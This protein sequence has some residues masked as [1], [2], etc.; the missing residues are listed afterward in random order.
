VDIDLPPADPSL[1]EIAVDLADPTFDGLVLFTAQQLDGTWLLVVD[2]AGRVVWA[3]HGAE[4]V[5]SPTSEFSRDGRSIRFT[6]YVP[7]DHSGGIERLAIDGREDTVFTPVPRGHHD[8]VELPDGTLAWWEDEVRDTEID[9]ETVRVVYDRLVEGPEGSAADDPAR[10]LVYAFA[11]D[12]P[13]AWM[14]CDHMASC[15]AE[16]GTACEFAHSNSLVYDDADDAYYT[17]SR[18]LDGFHRIDR[19]TGEMVWQ[20]GGRY[21][22]FGADLWRHGHFSDRWDGH[23]LV[24]DNANHTPGEVARVVEVAYDED[25]RTASTVWSY[26]DPDARTVEAIGDA[27]RLPDGDTL[28]S[29]GS[30]G[31]L[32]RHRADGTV[33]WR[34]R[35]PTVDAVGRVSWTP[36]LYHPRRK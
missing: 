32:T 34:I 27:Q 9:G 30:L 22:R 24:F 17:M 1:P 28:V 26:A 8:F 36:D 19:A 21:D 35:L 6:Q 13:A 23:V 7:R 14:V 10:R 2:G 18:W 29:W 31:E 25:A 16:D 15:N 11:D 5:A 33:R 20:L 3:H 4:L 12:Y